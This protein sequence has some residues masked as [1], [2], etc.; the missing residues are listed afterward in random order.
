[1]AKQNLLLVDADL[2]SVRV[3]EVSLRKAGYNVASAGNARDALAMLE[4]SRPDLVLCDTRLPAM[5]GFEFIQELRRSPEL[6]GIPLM[7]LSSDVSVET[8]VRG[9]ELGIEDY[10]TKPIYIKELLARVHIV[11]QRKRREGIE[12]LEQGHKRKFSGS[13]SD[14]GVVDLLQAIDHNKKSGVLYLTSG[15][16]D[17]AIY[18]CNG[19]AVDAAVG[20]LQG[21]RAIY[22]SLLWTEGTFEIDFREIDREDHVRTSMQAVLMEGLRRVDEWGRLLE[23]LPNLDTVFE[24]SETELIARLA[25]IPDEINSVLREFDGQRSLWDIVDACEAD[26]LETLSA[27]SKLY[28][29]GLLYNTGRQSSAGDKPRAAEAMPELTEIALPHIS[30]GPP[31]IT[32]TLAPAWSVPTSD[33]ESPLLVDD[34]LQL[35]IPA[36]PKVPGMPLSPSQAPKR[37]KPRKRKKRGVRS[38]AP[39]DAQRRSKAPV[40]A[41]DDAEV[42]EVDE[43]VAEITPSTI[44]PPPEEAENAAIL[45]GEVAPVAGTSKPPQLPRSLFASSQPA[46]ASATNPPEL[47]LRGRSAKPNVNDQPTLDLTPVRSGATPPPLQ[48]SL[49]PRDESLAPQT[50][51]AANPSPLQ[52]ASDTTQLNANSADSQP[53]LA[54]AAP[55]DAPLTVTSSASPLAAAGAEHSTAPLTTAT[56]P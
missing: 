28:F 31:V 54:A 5:D 18:F 29:E 45:Q 27:V 43:T 34:T 9:L 41:N 4:L 49:R 20:R 51:E 22:R 37:R 50:L 11:L 47:P 24:V 52:A 46:A 12:H 25:Y 38:L 39:N 2:R 40:R 17:G 56:A 32:H 15:R 36:T 10:L 55:S 30:S 42:L 35:N 44:A 7:I 53:P 26:D 6:A 21:S 33:G 19:A 48:P 13:L 3:L 1:M 8:K 23:Q 16:F 14:M